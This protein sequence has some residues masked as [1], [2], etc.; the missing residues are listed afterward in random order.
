MLFTILTVII[1]LLVNKLVPVLPTDSKMI[2]YP[3]QSLLL[4]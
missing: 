1:I 3:N 2:K 4:R